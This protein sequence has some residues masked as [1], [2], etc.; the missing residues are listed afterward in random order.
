MLFKLR[1]GFVAI[2][3]MLLLSAVCG[4]NRSAK[5]DVEKS[6]NNDTSSVLADKPLAA[7]QKDL[8]DL[9]FDTAS[10]IPANP[11]IKD[12]SRQQEAVVLACI[13]LDQPKRAL[14]YTEAI[15]NWLNGLCYANLAY[16]LVEHGQTN[17]ASRYLKIAA[18]LSESAEDWRKDRIRVRLAQ[19]HALLGQTPKA[20]L[21]ESGVADSEKGKVAPLKAMNGGKDAFDEQMKTL[22]AMIATGNFDLQR[23]ALESCVKLFNGFYS[24]AARRAL[25]E[26]KIRISWEKLPV[27]IRLDLLAELAGYAL[28]HA[29]KVKSLEL[30][31]D[32]QTMMNQYQWPME[33]R[34]PLIAKLAELRFRSGDQAKA[35]TDADAALALFD[36]P[37]QNTIVDIWRAGALRPLAHTYQMMGDSKASSSV[38]QQVVEEGVKNPNSRP[39]AED[40]TATC[41]AMALDG[42]E[43][44]TTFVGRLRQ[45]KKGLGNPW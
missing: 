13:K 31:N 15:E 6:V 5:A 22:D 12:R 11:H 45:I 16:Y 33:V 1:N 10:A 32:S 4:C 3:T 42:V 2:G 25:A 41:V 43:P 40:L 23:N 37:A 7:F 39:R 19:A 29:D 21:F 9:A 38:Y 24:D 8:L 35:R 14:Q 20:D 34:I 36:D 44:D 28:D 26:K 18:D 17:E 30:V 27:H